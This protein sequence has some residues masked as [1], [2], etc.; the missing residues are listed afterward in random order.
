MRTLRP[1][2]T[3]AAVLAM[4]AGL[5][6]AAVAQEEDSPLVTHVTGTVI[7]TFYDDSTAEATFAPEDVHFVNG[8][9]YVETNEWDDPRL[10][11]DKKMVLNFI[12]YPDAGGRF[13]VTRTSIRLDGPDGSW[14]G[15]GVG[16][17]DPDGSSH[18]QDVLVGEGA[19]EGLTAVLNCGTESGCEGYI[20]EGEM[21]PEPDPV[22]PAE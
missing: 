14:V 21:P 4:L 16:V 7:D 2:V 15:T 17:V 11:A 6:T 1:L 10:P 13:M 18:G 20:F 9:T 12:T 3:G 22:P 19:Y 8:A 5:G